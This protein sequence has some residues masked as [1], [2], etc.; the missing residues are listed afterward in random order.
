[1]IKEAAAQGATVVTG[2]SGNDNFVEPTVLVNC[3]PNMAVIK[4]EVFGPV[5][6]IIKFHAEEDA[7]RIAND[8]DA[9]LAAYFCTKDHARVWR[10]AQAL[11]VGMIGINEGISSSEV[12]PF[13]GVKMSGLG[14][15]GGRLGLVEY[16]SVKYLCISAL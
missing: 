4:H 16:L 10:I 15:E 7:V 2:G 5:V 11:Q 9:G 12:V 8:T 1:M 3:T 6:S 14:R 13:G